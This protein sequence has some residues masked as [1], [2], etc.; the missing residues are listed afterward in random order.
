M[1]SALPFNEIWAVDF[2]FNGE[3]GN[4]PNPVCMA[5]RELRSGRRLRLWADELGPEPPFSTGSNSLIVAYYAS[6]ELGCFLVLGW[7]MPANVLDLFAEFRV[8]TNTTRRPG[9][10]AA[11]L[12]AIL[13]HKLD[14]IGATEKDEMRSRVLRG[15]PWS[16]E[17]RLAILDYCETDV[18]ALAKLLPAMLSE[19]PLNLPQAL[20]RGRC[21]AANA[22]IEHNGTPIDVPMLERFRR[23][24]PHVQEELIARINGKYGIWEGKSFREHRFAAYLATNK[25]PWPRLESGRLDLSEETF[26][27]ISKSYPAITPIYEVRKDLSKLRLNELAVGSDSRNRCILSAFRARTGRNQ[28]SNSQFIFGPSA[29]LRSLIRPPED[30]AVSYLDFKQQEF[31]IAAALS[32]DPNMIKAY[33]TG[34]P[35]LAFAKQAG[36]VPLDATKQSHPRERELFKVTALGVLYGLSPYGLSVKLETPLVHARNLLR[37]HHEVYPKYWKWSD[38]MLDRAMLHGSLETAFGW[39]LHVAEA[40]NARSLRNFMM[41]GCGADMLRAACVLGTENAIEISAPVH[42]AV[43][44][45]APIDHIDADAAAMKAYMIEA[46]R[47]VLKGFE[48]GVDA[49]TFRFPDRYSDGERSAYMWETVTAVVT[50]AEARRA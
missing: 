37:A 5:A 47:G 8:R 16:N 6:A 22:V 36:A 39:E 34:D 15:G 46:S 13:R 19:Q 50:Q 33:Q 32:G 20:F 9:V 38:G 11:L 41:Q 40:P 24:W 4:R 3:P 29:W 44:I 7:P 21:M 23:H 26:R 35:Y 12:N 45:T 10:S 49:K 42:D 14:G 43:L 25:I 2:E 31:G 17:E 48:I 30:Y 18:D 28:P 1:L 27:I